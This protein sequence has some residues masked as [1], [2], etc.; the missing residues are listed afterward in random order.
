MNSSTPPPDHP[1]H[2]TM[3][4]HEESQHGS[5]I[6]A[7]EFR[8]P[9]DDGDSAI[10]ELDRDST[11][12][13]ASSIF[14]SREENG[15]TYHAYKDGKYVLPN[16]ERENDRQD[17]QNH[18]CLLTF[19]QKLSFA[20][21]TKVD[22]VLDVGTGTGIWAID[23]ADEHPEA[24][25]I[26]VDLSPHQPDFVP[27][28]LSFQIDDLEEPWNFSRK[29]DYVHSMMMTGAFRDW[30]R[31]YEQAF[32]NLESGGWVE[33]QDI[34]F[35]IRCDDDTMPKS[36]YL[37]QWSEILLEAS[38]TLGFKLDTCGKAK[39]MMSDVGFVDIIEVPFRWP[40]NR[41]PKQRKYKELGMW[42]QENFT[43]GL[44]AMSLALLTRGLGWSKEQVEVFTAFVRKDMCDQNIHAYWP[45]YVVYGRKP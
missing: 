18:L 23:F 16:D 32:E 37:Y 20:P 27:P 34:D 30:P 44:E 13:I 10:G 29:F 43:S 26:G 17:L 4:P 41:W 3:E 28:N 5:F 12:S 1:T 40:M 2:P 21:F 39:E 42:V 8:D 31:F 11:A 33:I 22:R 38:N 19:N 15:R 6:E 35:P 9:F 36:S 7:D 25:V 14:K 24:E 45:I